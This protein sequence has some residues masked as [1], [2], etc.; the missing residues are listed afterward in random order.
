MFKLMTLNINQYGD[1]H[2]KWE[3]RQSRIVQAIAAAKPDVIALQA[4]RGDLVRSE[5]QDQARQLASQLAGYAH[6]HFQAAHQHDDGRIDGLAF[7]A[8]VPLEEV[9]HH[10]LPYIDNPEDESHRLLLCARVRTAT[11]DWWIANGHFSWVPTV[12]DGNVQAALRC[13][14]DLRE[15]RLLVGDF[16]AVPESAGMQRLANDGW[17]DA[18]ARL[19]PEDNGFTFEA[20]VPA[21]R[22]D[23]VWADPALA[24]RLQ[25]IESFGEGEARFSDHLGLVVTLT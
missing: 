19:R 18:W 16:N 10:R 15:P 11:G 2:G 8:R 1:K 17:G 22:I 4:V 13:L 6:V 3:A 21:H 14:G 7:I 12:N 5:G 9:R 23:Y 20:D 25:I 24:P